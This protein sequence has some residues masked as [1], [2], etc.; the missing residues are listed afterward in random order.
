LVYG[1]QAIGADA[2]GGIAHVK[3]GSSSFEGDQYL[4]DEF[5]H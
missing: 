3:A 2:G 4:V 5:L 1:R